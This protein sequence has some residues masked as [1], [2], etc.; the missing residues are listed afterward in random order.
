MSQLFSGK[1]N[2]TEN[3]KQPGF[4]VEPKSGPFGAC[5]EGIKTKKHS[6]SAVLSCSG[7]Q[8]VSVA[9]LR[10]LLILYVRSHGTQESV[11]GQPLCDFPVGIKPSFAAL[12]AS[13]TTTATLKASF[14]WLS[15][16][17]LAPVGHALR[18]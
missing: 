5:L 4:Y 3:S 17:C 2:D 18:V 14:R 11:I 1:D 9:A 6:V 16:Q 12:T 13:I 8:D 7:T 15:L 10:L